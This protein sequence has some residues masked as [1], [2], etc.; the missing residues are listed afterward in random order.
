MFDR[1]TAVAA[2]LSI[3]TVTAA[4]LVVQQHA[5]GEERHVTSPSTTVSLADSASMT[6]SDTALGR[7]SRSRAAGSALHRRQVHDAA[8]A[9]TAAA[10][11]VAALGA[12]RAA[13]ARAA[14][15]AAREEQRQVVA[16]AE[17]DAQT[18]RAEQDRAAAGTR[19]SRS[20][21]RGTSTLRAG[22]AS[23]SAPDS[24]SAGRG[25]LGE[26]PDHAG[27][28]YAWGATG[29]DSFDCSGF[30]QYLFGQQGTQLPRTASDQYS[31]SSKVGHDDKQPGDLIFTYGDEGIFHVGVY[32]GGNTMWAATKSGDVVREQ[33]MWTSQ[34]HV[35]R[36]S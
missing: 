23:S 24:S 20:L 21:R 25:A 17:D 30:T 9:R 5:Q 29:P 14:R 13:R 36:F 12:A 26:A 4:A 8:A 32:A 15:A 34:Y 7:A 1:H 28:P 10:Q 33:E 22:G 18:A 2:A 3:T 11:R 31:A 35:G 19:A 27:K 6:R 16:Q